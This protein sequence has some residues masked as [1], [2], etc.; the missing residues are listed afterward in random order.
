[1]FRA[2][3]TKTAPPSTRT[4]RCSKTLYR[5]HL[6]YAGALLRVFLESYVVDDRF[7]AEIEARMASAFSS[8]G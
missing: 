4:R 3:E 7:S 1:M 6:V 2:R 8:T 5:D